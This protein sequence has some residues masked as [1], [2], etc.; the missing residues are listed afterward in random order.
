MVFYRNFSI[1]FAYWVISPLVILPS[2]KVHVNA[3]LGYLFCHCILRFQW[4][5]WMRQSSERQVP[6]SS[7]FQYFQH[8]FI[9]RIQ[10][11]NQR[12]LSLPHMICDMLHVHAW[13]TMLNI[14]FAW[15]LSFSRSRANLAISISRSCWYLSWLTRNLFS[16]A[17]FIQSTIP[18][19]IEL[20][21]NDTPPAPAAA[22]WRLQLRVPY[23]SRFHV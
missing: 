3:Y 23:N 4:W 18:L 6:G 15:L 16:A 2:E 7:S 9:Q 8:N 14:S 21:T 11:K 19:Q 12:R 22:S 10:I 13:K 17:A 5:I 20:V 1:F